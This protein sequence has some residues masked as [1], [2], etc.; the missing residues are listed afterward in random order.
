[1]PKTLRGSK[2][3]NLNIRPVPILLGI[4]LLV[5][6]YYGISQIGHRGMAEGLRE[7]IQT[8]AEGM[9]TFQK[10][11]YTVS[12]DYLYEYDIVALVLHT[13]NYAPMSV[14]DHLAPKD[15]ALGWGDV[16]AKNT[17]ID[18]HWNQS[19][20]F[21]FW[22]V[23]GTDLAKIGGEAVVSTQSAN[24]HIIAADSGV[25]HMISRIKMGDV[26]HL[27]GYLVS[28]YASKPNGKYY[29]WES[30]TTRT[31]TGDG[32]CELIYVTSAEIL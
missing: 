2:Q 11:G 21:Y 27:K 5:V 9:T 10:D 29:F 31:D 22:Y 20:R 14:L 26:I 17:E 28:V 1:M 19:G 32:A 23:N 8:P 7:P 18:F 25:R 6:A 4:A 30:S 16:A 13:K 12:V 3:F 15:L 24:C